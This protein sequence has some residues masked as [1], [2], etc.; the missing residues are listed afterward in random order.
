MDTSPEMTPT[1]QID[2]DGQINDQN[3]QLNPKNPT[4]QVAGKSDGRKSGCEPKTPPG[5]AGM[6]RMTQFLKKHFENTTNNPDDPKDKHLRA[7]QVHDDQQEG[8]VVELRFR[9][10]KPKSPPTRD[11]ENDSPPGISDKNTR[12]LHWQLSQ[13]LS[14]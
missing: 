5:G 1:D 6:T 10:K 8:W 2:E 13:K 12:Q 14:K 7:P 3:D 4:T 11:A 9:K